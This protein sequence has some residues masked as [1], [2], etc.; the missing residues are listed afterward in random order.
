M[1]TGGSFVCRRHGRRE[2]AEPGEYEYESTDRRGTRLIESKRRFV[3]FG[4]LTCAD[5][6]P[7]D[8]VEAL[9]ERAQ[10]T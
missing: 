4:H 3:G 9:R 1:N 2:V 5:A 8:L 10:R 6:A 7:P